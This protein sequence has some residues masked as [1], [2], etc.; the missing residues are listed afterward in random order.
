MWGSDYPNSDGI[1]P[2]SRKWIAVDLV[3]DS[4]AV[5]RK[6]VCENAGKLD[7]LP[8]SRRCDRASVRDDGQTLSGGS[9]P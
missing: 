7:R 3:S 6:I 1:W 8:E 4:P 9:G 2:D 5:Q